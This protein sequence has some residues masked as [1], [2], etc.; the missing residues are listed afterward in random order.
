MTTLSYFLK[1]A[2]LITINLLAVLATFSI[3][4]GL[5]QNTLGDI[6]N[7]SLA[8]SKVMEKEPLI[9][10]ELLENALLAPEEKPIA[11]TDNEAS[12][13]ESPEVDFNQRFK[14]QSKK[15]Q[16]VAL[17]L[18]EKGEQL[19][20]EGK[21]NSA[22]LKFQEALTLNPHLNFEPR[23]QAQRLYTLTLVE[24][25]EQ[26]AKEGAIDTA[27][28]KFQEAITLNPDLNF[29]PQVQAQRLYAVVL[30][31]QGSQFAH[32][33]DLETAIA[34]FEEALTLNPRL[35]FKPKVKARQIYAPVLVRHGKQLARIGEIEKSVADYVRAQKMDPCLIIP[36]E[37]WALLCIAGHTYEQAEKVTGICE[38]IAT[39]ED[40]KVEEDLQMMR[41]FARALIGDTSSAREDFEIILETID[42]IDG[43]QLIQHWI[44]QLQKGENPFNSIVLKELLEIE[45]P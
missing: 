44:A 41:G 42:Y 20:K 31:N 13:P 37:Y 28:V 36:D 27:V 5:S 29:E 8:Q 39:L 15:Q 26:L 1:R 16:R 32:R 34:K 10:K 21:I 40:I 6:N 12:Q 14:L 17:E 9:Q 43:R 4:M 38:R 35:N 3:L 45:T 33:G 19:A 23:Y 2:H 7:D 22:V 25:G 18:V 24:K 11:E 30:V